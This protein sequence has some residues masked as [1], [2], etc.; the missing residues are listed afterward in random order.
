M[1]PQLPNFPVQTGG[2][3][4]CY[5]LQ[6]R[7]TMQ[8]YEGLEYLPKKLLPYKK[9][10]VIVGYYLVIYNYHKFVIFAKID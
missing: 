5:R 1:I 10:Y 7:I 4:F 3:V 8:S 9:I 6:R 2:W